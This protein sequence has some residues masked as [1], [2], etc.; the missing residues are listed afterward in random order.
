MIKLLTLGDSIAHGYR[1]HLIKALGDAYE[2]STKI[3]EEE[4]AKNLN[5]PVGS[6]CGD[7]RMMLAYLTD[8]YV[9]GRLDKY[10]IIMLNC[11]Q[12]D[13]KTNLS[14]GKR[15][16]DADEYEA[17]LE[18]I[19]E[20]VTKTDAQLWFVN[21]T[22]VFEAVHNTPENIVINKN[23]VRYAKDVVLCN[24]AASRVMGKYGIPIIDLYSLTLTF[25]EHA[26]RDHAH[27]YPEYEQR[28][29]EF[30]AEIIRRGV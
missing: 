10:D 18:K 8:E 9:N 24:E 19:C 3:G 20:V 2:V 22:P 23:I 28:Q 11:G 30:L 15:Q 16:I 6:N 17:N 12:H 27:Y 4:A 29:G 25:T 1:K 14:T 21:T 5:I 7:S 13:V 26:L